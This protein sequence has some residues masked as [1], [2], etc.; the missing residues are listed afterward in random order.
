M[1]VLNL[2]NLNTLRAN[3]ERLLSAGCVEKKVFVLRS[4]AFYSS[5]TYFFG[6]KRQSSGLHCEMTA[7]IGACPPTAVRVLW[8]SSF[9]QIEAE[10]TVHTLSVS[11]ETAT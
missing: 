8:Y 3:A 4:V 5:A 11:M 2:S 1:Y 10:A 7:A 6:K 9:T